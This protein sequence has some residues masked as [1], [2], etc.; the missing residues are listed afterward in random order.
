MACGRAQRLEYGQLDNTFDFD[1]IEGYGPTGSN[2]LSGSLSGGMVADGVRR[3]VFDNVKAWY[4]RNLV[5]E[6]AAGAETTFQ[7]LGSDWQPTPFRLRKA[8]LP[9]SPDWCRINGMPRK[10]AGRLAIIRHMI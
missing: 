9:K 6:I 5:F 8:H 10:A 7:T 3:Y 1:S 4:I 2:V